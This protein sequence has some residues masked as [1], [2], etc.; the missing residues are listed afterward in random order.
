[1]KR[2]TLIGLMLLALTS[3]DETIRYITEIIDGTI[4]VDPVEDFLVIGTWTRLNRLWELGEYGDFQYINTDDMTIINEGVYAMDMDLGYMVFADGVTLE[5]LAE[6]YYTAGYVT[7]ELAPVGSP[8]T[9]A[10][11][12]RVY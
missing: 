9:V 5:V 11:W 3:C 4:Y 1:M 12:D 10:V 2:L 6:Y 8:L 7:L